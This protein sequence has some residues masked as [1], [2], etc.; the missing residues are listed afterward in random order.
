ME[1][2]WKVAV[3]VCRVLMHVDVDGGGKRHRKECRGCLDRGLLAP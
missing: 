2:E 1:G 3:G